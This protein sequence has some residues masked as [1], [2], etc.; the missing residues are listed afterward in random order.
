MHTFLKKPK[1]STQFTPINSTITAQAHDKQ[2]LKVNPIL[3]LQRA[4]GNQAVQGLLEVN[5]KG[6]EQTTSSDMSEGERLRLATLAAAEGWLSGG[7]FISQQKIDDIRNGIVRLPIATSLDGSVITIAI[8]MK[9]PMKNYTTCIEFAGQ[10]Y[11]DAVRTTNKGDRKSILRRAPMLAGVLKLF[12]KEVGLKANIEAFRK[13][14]L[15]FVEPE[16]NRED[17]RKEL[18]RNIGTL[19]KKE[20]ATLIETQQ[21]KAKRQALRQIEA[22]IAN[23]AAQKAKI[24]AKIDKLEGQLVDVQTRNK[25]WVRPEPGL[26]GS[27]PK[28]GEFILF[29]QPPGQ[30]T[31]GVSKTTT[32]SLLPGSFKHISIFKSSEKIGDEIERWNTIDGGGTHAKSHEYY[33]RTTD[34]LTFASQPKKEKTKQVAQAQ[35]ILLGWIDT[36]MLVEKENVE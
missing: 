13:S 36:D 23:V 34:L 9:T 8:Q 35:Y 32:V 15:M 29:G 28:P 6:S 33:V 26:S 24:Q 1:I 3:H 21:L 20:N 2:S 7:D 11:G 4:V 12:N 16:T 10:V 22:A 30:S 27:R 17:Q 5:A 14:L 25:A 18:A 31:Y 19:E